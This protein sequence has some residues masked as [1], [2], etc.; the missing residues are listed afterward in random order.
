[1]ST[2]QTFTY[3]GDQIKN[4]SA[5]VLQVASAGAY[6]II[7]E[8]TKNNPSSDWGVKINVNGTQ[9]AEGYQQFSSGWSHVTAA[10][11]G[12]LNANDKVQLGIMSGASGTYEVLNNSTMLTV[13]K[14][15]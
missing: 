15:Y 14:L 10:W 6:L 5:G 9:K 1:M 7:G 13:I 2:Q 4:P 12:T 3:G 11:A 8:C